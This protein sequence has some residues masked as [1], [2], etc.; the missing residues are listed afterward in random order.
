MD[1]SVIWKSVKRFKN[2]WSKGNNNIY[3]QYKESIVLSV[4]SNLCPPWAAPAPP[5][6]SHYNFDPFLD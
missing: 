5:S 2:R 6:F 3:S 1:P 4:I